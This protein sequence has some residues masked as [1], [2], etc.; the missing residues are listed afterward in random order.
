MKLIGLTGNIGTGKTTVAKV[1][2]TLG[3]PVYN[4]DFRAKAIL[5]SA[6]NRYL[7]QSSFGTG[8]FDESGNVDRKALADIVFKNADKLRVLNDLIHPLVKN[9]FALWC[10]KHK[11]SPYLLHEAAILFESGFHKIFDAT[12]LVTAPLELCVSRAMARDHFTK[13]QLEYRIRNQWPQETKQELA[14]YLIVNDDNHLVIPQVL[15]VHR[16]ILAGIETLPIG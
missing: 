13:E 4:A 9:E 5:G 3:I 6:E 11:K 1:F 7:L 10:L 2:E 15:E 8:I 16:R 12:I 14:D